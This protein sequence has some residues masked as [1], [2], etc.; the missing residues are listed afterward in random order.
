MA[1]PKKQRFITA[2]IVEGAEFKSV[3]IPALVFSNASA[4]YAHSAVKLRGIEISLKNSTVPIK[5]KKNTK[6]IHIYAITKV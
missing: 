3:A 5:P 1:L 6:D 4:F 2:E